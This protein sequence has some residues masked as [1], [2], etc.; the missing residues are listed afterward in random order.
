MRKVML[1]IA[2]VFALAGSVNPS[3]AITIFTP[4]AAV[5]AGSGAAV[6]VAGGFLGAVAALCAYDIWLKI[7]GLKNWDGTAKVARRGH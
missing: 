1:A 5:A 4:P 6:F 2:V 3:R 7:N